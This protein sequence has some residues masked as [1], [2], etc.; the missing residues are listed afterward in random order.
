MKVL[1]KLFGG[2]HWNWMQIIIFGLITGIYTGIIMSI[3]ALKGTS[4]RDIGIGYEWWILFAMLIITNCQTAKE[5]ALK[6]FVFF[7]ISQ[8]IIFLIQPDGI[9]LFL[10][11]YPGWMIPTLATLPMAYIGWHTRKENLMSALIL[12][13][14]LFMLMEHA[15]SYWKQRHILSF[16]FCILQIILL[17]S[18][19]LQ[20]K[21]QRIL[22]AG[23]ALLFFLF[24]E[25]LLFFLNR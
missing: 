7:L 9:R 15:F 25:T 23:I 21:K 10:T 1:K 3:P 13:A 17:L 20:N 22:S 11:Y 8:P 5:S 19:V 16:V 14:M 4:F 12:S 24:F 6:T 2:L 18:G